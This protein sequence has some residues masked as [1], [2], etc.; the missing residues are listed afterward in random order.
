MRSMESI[1]PTKDSKMELIVHADEERAALF[2]PDLSCPALFLYFELIQK[3]KNNQTRV[4]YRLRPPPPKDKSGSVKAKENWTARLLNRAHGSRDKGL[5]GSPEVST[6][7]V[8]LAQ[9]AI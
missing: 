9:W 4:Q 1:K 3:G 7:K 2:K 8:A 5:G 6:P